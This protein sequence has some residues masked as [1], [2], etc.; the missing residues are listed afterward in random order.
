MSFG[1]NNTYRGFNGPKIDEEIKLDF[2]DVL[3][4][5]QRSSLKS[6]AEVDLD[7]VFT[8]KHSANSWKGTP[9]ISSNMDT[10]GTFEMAVSLAKYKCLTTVHKYYS[11]NDWKIFAIRKPEALP[12]V[13]VSAG[14][15]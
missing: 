4:R 13:A 15:S 10:T 8:F 9:I 11:I 5:P 6:R 14:T 7:R 1:S 12:F 3:F 2:N